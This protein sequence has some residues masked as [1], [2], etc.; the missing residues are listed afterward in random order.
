[1]F[2]AESTHLQSDVFK[3]E[4]FKEHVLNCGSVLVHESVEKEFP[5]K[6]ALAY[7]W[8]TQND[9]PHTLLV[10]VQRHCG[11]RRELKAQ[12]VRIYQSATSGCH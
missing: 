10:L 6:A 11:H 5:Q 12:R 1:M 4:F 2:G 9:Q 3:I 8:P 7:L